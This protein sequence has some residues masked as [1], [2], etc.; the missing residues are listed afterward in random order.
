M[1]SKLIVNNFGPIKHVDLDLRNVNV[2]I[3]EQATGKS[4][5]AKIYTIFKAPRK[6]FY[7]NDSDKLDNYKAS[8]DFGDIFEDYNIKAFLKPNTEIRFESALHEFAYKNGRVQ[9][10]PKLKITISKIEK[11]IE[12][13]SINE[14]EIATE[15]LKLASNFI[16]FSIRASLVLEN[17]EHRSKGLF[18]LTH[19]IGNLNQDNCVQVIQLIKDIEEDLSTNTALYIPAERNFSSIIKKS[20][21]NLILNKV[22]IPKHILT[23]VAEL[24]KIDTKEISLN[25]IQKDLIYKNVNG[26]D[27]IFTDIDHN[28]SLSEAASGIQSVIPILLPI[29]SKKDVNHRSF[30]IEEPELNLF[31]RAQYDL[32]QHLE[33]NRRE[34]LWPHWEDFGTIH[35]YTTHSPYILSALNNLLY[36]FKVKEELNKRIPESIKEEER[37]ELCEANDRK[38]KHIV[39]AYI[40]PKS[41]SAYQICG[42]EAKSIFNEN[43]GL[44]EDNYIDESSDEIN[45][46][47]EE[48]MELIQ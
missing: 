28:I 3:G 9:Y 1:E 38:I 12:S 39:E 31:P 41:F 29:L 36:A 43:S 37:N 7:K 40:N 11:L 10:E 34:G 27:R 22:P 19:T 2:F 42:G 23:F 26:E 24:E 46:D 17:E 32:I 20:V 6:F 35:T 4:A 13:F 15:L 8:K 18:S 21:A 30:V 5:L 47:F 44:I 14:G 33:S 45:D 16:L 25:F 48:L